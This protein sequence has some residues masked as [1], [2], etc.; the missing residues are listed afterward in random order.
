[1]ANLPV[2]TWT[3]ELSP[4]EKKTYELHHATDLKIT[5]AA[6]A[7]EL[8]DAN[9]RSTVVLH[10]N[11]D[12]LSSDS[13]DS[14]EED[15]SESDYSPAPPQK[16]VLTSLTPG[17]VPLLIVKLVSTTLITS[18]RLNLVFT[19]LSSPVPQRLHLKSLAKSTQS[20]NMLYSV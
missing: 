13:E 10:I 1:M 11:N 4:S 17:K 8:A 2:A 3:L 6:L 19:I 15:K 14:D 16:L 5:N 9:A 7:H 12:P 20:Q 18:F